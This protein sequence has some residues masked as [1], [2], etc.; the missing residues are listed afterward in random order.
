MHWELTPVSRQSA[1]RCLLTGVCH[2]ASPSFDPVPNYTTSWQTHMFVCNYQSAVP[3]EINPQ[4][5]K[6]E[7][8]LKYYSVEPVSLESI[9]IAPLVD[10]G[11]HGWVRSCGTPDSL[12]LTHGLLLMT[13][14]HGG[15]YDP[16]PVTRSSEWVSKLYVYGNKIS[17]TYSFQKNCKSPLINF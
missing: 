2:R 5:P 8:C 7:Q 6:Y 16:Q 1:H 10:H 4:P 3:W 15:C 14:Q 9:G 12:L 11:L 13:G 17:I